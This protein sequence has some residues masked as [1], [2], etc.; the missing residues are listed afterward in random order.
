M[1]RTRFTSYNVRH[2]LQG[3]QCLCLPVSFPVRH[4]LS[5][6]VST[7]KGKMCIPKGSKFLPLRVDHFSK[8]KQNNFDRAASPK[9]VSFS[10]IRVYALCG[11]NN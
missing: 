10:L 4:V 5:E 7:L 2:G 8:G 9:S 6:K 11:S 3:R 1:K